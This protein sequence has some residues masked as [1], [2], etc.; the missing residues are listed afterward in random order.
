M[1]VA[2]CLFL[3]IPSSWPFLP[4]QLLPLRE[5]ACAHSNALLTNLLRTAHRLSSREQDPL[6]AWGFCAL[7]VTR[8]L[9]R[10]MLFTMRALTPVSHL[11][12]SRARGRLTLRDSSTSGWCV[13]GLLQ[14]HAV[15]IHKQFCLPQD[16]FSFHHHHH[17]H[18]H[19][20]KTKCFFFA[21]DFEMFCGNN[22]FKFT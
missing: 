5:N 3:T 6:R 1:E 14:I 15:W 9:P 16:V 10:L 18:H 17:H 13:L 22:H 21:L 7:F 11:Y 8:H 2:E 4:A 19:N 20:N 12:Q